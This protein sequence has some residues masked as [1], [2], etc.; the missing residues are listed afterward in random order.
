VG[1]VTGK[2][3]KNTYIWRSKEGITKGTRREKAARGGRRKNVGEESVQ[4]TKTLIAK[5]GGIVKEEAL[6]PRAA[7]DSK[8]K[9][10]P[11][12]TASR[13]KSRSYWFP[14]KGDRVR[15]KK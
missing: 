3:K 11:L 12:R 9:Q 15:K 7:R 4:Q 5:K 6:S 10:K 2:G 1:S 14:K 8:Q 13:G